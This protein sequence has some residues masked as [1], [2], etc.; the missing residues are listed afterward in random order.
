MGYKGIVGNATYQWLKTIHPELEIV[1]KDKGDIL[2]EGTGIVHIICTPESAVIEVCKAIVDTELIVIRSTVPPGT[3]KKI[4]KETGIHI[5]HLP[6]FLLEATAVIDEFRQGYLVLGACCNQHAEI[7]GDI[8]NPFIP[9]V[10][11]D[12]ETSEVLKLTKNC[13]F[14]NLIS[15]WNEMEAIAKA[16]G[17]N[18][19]KVGKLATLDERIVEYGASY[20]HKYGGTCLPKDMKQIL[21]F[22]KTHNIKTPL[23]DAVTEV[24]EC[25][26]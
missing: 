23:L 16:A 18:S 19:H 5:C 9:V 22:A 8:Y 17:T 13:Y 25:L 11:T 2:S 12:T 26:E 20:H 6:E 24:N 14:A 4:Q 10:T 21:G 1:G 15:F 7:I 3:C